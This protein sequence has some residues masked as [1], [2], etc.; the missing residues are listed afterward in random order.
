MVE[1]Y[2]IEHDREICIGCAACASVCPNYWVMDSDG[3]SD[4]KGA[5]R[6]E[7]DGKTW[8]FLGNNQAPLTQDYDC[9]KEAADSCPVNC[10]HIH[11]VKDDGS[12]ERII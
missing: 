8:E 2:K 9:N 7:R 3:K 6:K 1:K 4:I 10:I 11:E 12:D 5:E